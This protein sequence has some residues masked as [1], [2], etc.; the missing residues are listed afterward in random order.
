MT[1]DLSGE[2]RITV[3]EHVVFGLNRATVWLLGPLAPTAQTWLQAVTTALI[4]AVFLAVVIFAGG[5]LLLWALDVFVCCLQA[6]I[7]ALIPRDPY[8]GQ[9]SPE[10]KAAQDERRAEVVA[11]ATERWSA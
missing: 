10:W 4:M 6:K 7:P 8:C 1:P 11:A 9:V 3:V 2:T 5:S